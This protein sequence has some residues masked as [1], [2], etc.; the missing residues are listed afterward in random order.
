M[1]DLTGKVALVTGGKISAFSGMPKP[2]D[3]RWLLAYP[4]AGHIKY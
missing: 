2:D 1:F 4:Q 3:V